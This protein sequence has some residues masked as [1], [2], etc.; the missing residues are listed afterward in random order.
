MRPTHS[1]A[2]VMKVRTFGGTCL[3]AGKTIFDHFADI[4]FTDDLKLREGLTLS[5]LLTRHTSGSDEAKESEVSPLFVPCEV[6]GTKL[7]IGYGSNMGSTQTTAEQLAHEARMMGYDVSCLPLDECMGRLPEAEH[8]LAL[9]ASYNGHPPDNARAFVSWVEGLEEGALSGLSFSVLGCGHKDWA[10]TYQAIPKRLDAALARAGASRVC[11]RGEAD[12]RENMSDEL[13]RWRSS[14]WPTFHAHLGLSVDMPETAHQLEVE[15]LS[16]PTPQESIPY[17]AVPMVVEENKELVD[18]SWPFARSKRHLRMAL[19]EGSSYEAGDYLVVQPS[20]LPEYVASFAQRLGWDLEQLVVLRTDAPA[21]LPLER[22]ISLGMLLTR[23][24]ELQHPLSLSEAKAL[25]PYVLCP[26]EKETLSRWCEDDVLL[27]EELYQKKRNLLDLLQLFPSLRPPLSLVLS[28]LPVLKP[29]Y[30]SIASSPKQHPHSC[31]ITVSV[32][33]GPS[34]SGEGEYLGVCSNQL[35]RIQP[36]ASVLAWIRRP[37][38]AF[39]PPQDPQVPMVMIAAG[40]GVAPFRGFLQERASRGEPC[41]KSALFFGCDHP[42]V[43]WLYKEELA[44]WQEEG[45]V[46]LHTAFSEAPDE[47]VLF[48]QHR[49]WREK[50]L[51]KELLGRGAVF[52]VC[53]D[54]SKM[55]PAVRGVLCRIYQE[56]S[57]C[58]EASAQAWLQQLRAD[59]RLFEDVWAA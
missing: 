12:A 2:N 21:T 28:M 11:E 58:D 4:S 49:L 7:L 16:P 10:A 30:Y 31:E 22:P 44:S 36:G 5:S 32:L 19:P 6:H 3:V 40:T 29:R 34:R 24:I 45:L 35:A 47:E 8:F 59:G 27:Q 57:G 42:E 9:S 48:V 18:M 25:L 14:F 54:G 23:Y 52:Y 1:W 15:E 41:A 56:Q 20:N 53:G 51:V 43:D 50:E 39:S 38:P 55:A 33:A 13:G 26:P 37:K 46:S 17:D